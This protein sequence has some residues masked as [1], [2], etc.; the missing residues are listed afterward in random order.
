VPINIKKL[1]NPN[2]PPLPAVTI[3]LGR[4][5]YNKEKKKK[6]P[7]SVTARPTTTATTNNNHH[8]HHQPT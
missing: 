5:S 1:Q 4:Y 2:V 6:T 8:H 7:Q 3:V